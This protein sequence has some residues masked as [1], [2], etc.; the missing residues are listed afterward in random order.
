MWLNNRLLLLNHTSLFSYCFRNKEKMVVYPDFRI[1]IYCTFSP[2]KN[3]FMKKLYIGVLFLFA[4]LSVS[5]QETKTLWQKDIK[6][7]TQ[8]FLTQLSITIDGQYL[9]SGSSIQPSKISSVSSDGSANQ[10]NGY[11][12]HVMKLNQQGQQVWEKYFSGNR[13][14]YLAATTATKEGGFL[15]AGTSYSTLGIDKKEK[16]FG[17]SDIWIIKIDEN[18]EEEWQKTIGTQYGDEARSVIQ[19]LDLGYVVA[20]NTNLSSQGFGGTDVLLSKLDKNGK[21]IYQKVLGGSDRD[22]VEKV[23]PTKDGGCLIGIYSYSGTYN[24]KKKQTISSQILQKPS[25]SQN[26]P[27]NPDQPKPVDVD[28]Y[29]KQT[30]NYGV[31]DYRIVKLDRSGKVEWEQN[32]GGKSDDHLRQLS[33]TEDGY[34]IGGESRSE[35]SGNKRPSLKEGTDLWLI[36][37]NEDGSEK[38][39]YSYNFGNRDILMS[40]DAIK[41]KENK[42][43]GFL[44]GGYTQAE[45]KIQ[46]DDGKFWMLYINNEGKEEWRKHVEGKSKKKEERLVSAKLQNDGTFLLAGT[47]AEEL[48]QENWKILKLG[49]KDLDNLI[50]KQDI[51]IYPNPVEDYCYVEIG[52]EFNGE[53]EIALHDMTGRVIQNI[54][55]KNSVTK[56]N[57]SALPQGVYVV[58]AKTE[59]KVVNSKIVKK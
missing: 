50:E 3:Q 19:T 22:E 7:S 16:S 35:S 43:K 4:I 51:R 24:G 1:T 18:G 17:R 31:G 40:M 14:D 5:A 6:S 10:N 39:Q 33:F 57:T 32:F 11:D 9:V 25:N 26:N 15:L 54:K 21:L 38:A 59:K 37:L 53:A 55:T 47:S 44:V 42:T 46:T 48:G 36:A 20:G 58:S 52:F 29:G 56:M 28:F 30:E 34:V 2:L 41:D 8:D 13:H 12:F 45:E 49:D 27:K 23:I